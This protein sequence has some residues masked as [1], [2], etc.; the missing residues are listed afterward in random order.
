MRYANYEQR[1]RVAF[2]MT[3]TER[4]SEFEEEQR[5]DAPK[6]PAI[7]VAEMARLAALVKKR[8]AELD[9]EEAVRG[10]R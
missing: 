9:E 5:Q 7:S 2:R 3:G 1:E 4:E 10:V 8:L 6:A